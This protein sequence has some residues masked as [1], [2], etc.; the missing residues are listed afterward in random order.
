MLALMHIAWCLIH[1]SLMTADH[2]A[3]KKFASPDL[4]VAAHIAEQTAQFK[5]H[6][7]VAEGAVQQLAN[8][9]DSTV[10]TRRR[11]AAFLRD[12]MTTAMTTE[13]IEFEPSRFTAVAKFWKEIG[14]FAPY[15]LKWLY[16]K[17]ATTQPDLFL[18]ST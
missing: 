7:A 18:L 12:T 2:M 15:D 14:Y 3:R 1:L 10:L 11:P 4:G 5:R 13:I 9:E 8:H 6:L 16:E 17:K